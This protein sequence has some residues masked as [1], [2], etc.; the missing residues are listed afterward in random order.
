MK[1]I[2]KQILV[3]LITLIIVPAFSLSLGTYLGSKWA[4][5]KRAKNIEEI[6][7]LNLPYYED[8]Y[9]NF[10]IKVYVGKNVA[11]MSWWI[12]E[13]CVSDNV[14]TDVYVD[15]SYSATTNALALYSDE[16]FEY[17]PKIWIIGDSI[18][19]T[20]DNEDFIIGGLNQSLG[21]VNYIIYLNSYYIGR[22]K[23]DGT[24]TVHHEIF[25]GVTNQ[26]SE[27]EI[28]EFKAIEGSCSL[29]SEY[30]CSDIY[31]ELSETWAYGFF[32]DDN[33]KANYLHEKY[34]Y[35]LK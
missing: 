13:N 23:N 22:L 34:S 28:A 7:D 3:F 2:I 24:W 12:Q 30:A 15:K 25:H 20:R 21:H 9:Q 4:D 11:E 5:S 17:I 1:K 14:L 19:Q 26:W 29:V 35:L 33:A 27:K 31:E 18:I 16:A 32:H 6:V 10:D 8:I